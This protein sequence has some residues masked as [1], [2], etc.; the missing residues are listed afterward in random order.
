MS[1]T[2]GKHIPEKMNFA[3]LTPIKVIERECLISMITVLAPLST[4]LE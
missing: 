1:N 2:Y 4:A 3:L